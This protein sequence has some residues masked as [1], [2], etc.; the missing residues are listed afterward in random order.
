VHPS[1]FQEFAI[2][3]ILESF[4]RNFLELSK[5]GISTKQD[6]PITEAPPD[7]PTEKM[8][9]CCHPERREGS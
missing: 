7:D 9:V 6:S 8:F 5:S 1:P 4:S 3:W 2:K